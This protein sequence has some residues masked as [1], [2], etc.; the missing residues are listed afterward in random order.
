MTVAEKLE[1][2]DVIWSDLRQNTEKLPPPEWH[3][4]VLENRRKAFERGE[5]SYTD[6]EAAKVEIRKRIS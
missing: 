1:A 2:L 6:W 5:V 3:K 4:E